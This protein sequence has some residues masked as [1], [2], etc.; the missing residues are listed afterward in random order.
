MSE[1]TTAIFWPEALQVLREQLN[2]GQFT[3][4]FSRTTCLGVTDQTLRIGVPNNFCCEWLTR[5]Y[6]EQV[7]AVVREVSGQAL[8]VRFEVVEAFDAEPIH[9]PDSTIDQALPREARFES[10]TLVSASASAA[11][12]RGFQLNTEYTFDDFVVGPGNR[13]AHAAAM[14][15]VE[16]TGRIYNPLFIHGGLGLGKTH[17]LQGICHNLMAS[18]PDLR[19]LYTPCEQFVN[20]FIAALEKGKVD[21]FRDQFR[22]LDVLVIDDIHF[23]ANKEQSQEEFFHTFNVLYEQQKQIILSSDSAPREIPTLEERLVSRFKWGLVCKMEKPTFETRM[24]IIH[25]KAARQGVS[26]PSEVVEH[27]AMSLKTSVRELEGAVTSL[28]GYCSLMN[29]PMVLDTVRLALGDLIGHQ[30][31]RVTVD[32]IIALVTDHFGV[33]LADLQSKKRF[34]S[35]TLP[36][37]VCMYL[38]RRY[39]NHSLAEIGGY[40]GGRD[41]STVLYATEKIASRLDDSPK[42]K[43]AVEELCRQLDG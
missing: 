31:K 30:K 28:I 37:Q 35:I 8:S 17:L 21:A 36:R 23:L 6:T 3:T 1:K 16:Q 4:W 39:T 15:V 32:Q 19:I 7:A 41:H 27:L 5:Q 43:V 20:R 33:K 2:E 22:H 14:A 13:M 42:L 9:S 26:L 10:N 12:V 25:K 18:Q 40:F 34:Q 11:P 29:E 38:A 24:A